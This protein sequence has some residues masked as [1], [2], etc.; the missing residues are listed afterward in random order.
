LPAR[1]P[2][3]FYPLPKPPNMRNLR[4]QTAI[5]FL[6]ILIVGAGKAVAA[7]QPPDN[8]E[9]FEQKIRP[10]LAQRCFSCHSAKTKS[11]QGGLLLDSRAGW[12]RGGGSGSAV[13]PGNPDASLLIKAVRYGSALKMPPTGKLPES[14]I[15]LLEDW[16]KRGAPGPKEAGKPIAQKTG[17]KW[18]SFQPLHSAAL[19]AV[20]NMAWLRTPVDSFILAKLEQKGMKPSPPADRRALIRRATFDLTGLPPT[21]SEI[22][23][24]LSD[25]SPSAYEKVIDRLLISPRYGER[26]GRHWLDVVHYGDTHGYDKDKRRDRAWLYR[27]YVIKAFNDDKPYGRFIREQIAGDVLYPNTPEGIIA[28]GFIVAGPW[29]FV[30]EVE[31]REGTVEKEKTRLL[32]RDDMVANTISTFNS[33]TIHCAR[34]HNHKFDPIPQR[35]YYRLQ[36]VFAGVERGD[37]PFGDRQLIAQRSLL[38]KQQAD[39]GKTQA[40]L[41]KEKNALTSAELTRLDSELDVLKKALAD[42]HLP[43]LDSPSNGY[44]SAISDTA[45]VEKWVQVDLGR[46]IPIDEIRLIPARPTDFPD[47]PGFGFPVRFRVSVSDDPG[48]AASRVIEDLSGSDYPN[49]GDTPFII[50]A[51]GSSTR[52]IRVTAT[53]LWKRTG[54]YVFALAE[55]QVYSQGRNV[56]RGA[57]VTS[58]DSIEAGRWSAKYL[59]DNFD[60]RAALLDASNPKIAADYL[61]RS[62]LQAG[63]KEKESAR[64][65]LAD[66]LVSP[67]LRT[68]IEQVAEKIAAIEKQI[69]ALPKP[70]TA[71]AALSR[72]PRPIHVLARGE[73]TQPGEEVS[74]GGLTCLATLPSEFKT[75]DPQDE[76]GRRAALAEWLS[77]PKNVLTWRS[78]V[79]RVWHYH[80]GRGLVDTPNDFG[81]NG[82][83]P[84]HPELL[85]W[86]AGQF[87]KDGQSIKKLHRL[88]ML[89]AT[90]RQSSAYNPQYAKSDADNHFLWRMNRTR[91]DAESVRDSVMAV[92]GVLDLKMGGP[93]FE[94][95]R[96]KDD[97]SPIYDHSAVEKINSPAAMRRTVYRFVVRSVPNP[98]LDCLDCADPNIN[99]PVRNTTLT[100]LQAL[101]LMNDPFIIKQSEAFAKRLSG[102]HTD[103]AGQINAVYNLALGRPATKGEIAALSAYAGKHGLA[104]ACRLIFNTNEFVFVD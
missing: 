18:W 48:F 11:P 22:A 26:W 49:P 16:V 79:N 13:V 47:T 66:T 103:I 77:N 98:F 83:L 76:G 53:R 100:A 89:S 74:A 101:A 55:M 46:S 88:I 39:L 6:S 78:I 92:S 36:A 9:F 97:H 37:R 67:N 82:S 25:R 57:A 93:G 94:L 90:Y 61:R 65:A 10:L 35:D 99:T 81:R 43:M 4:L 34:C 5:A 70:D 72:A 28:T 30:G 52:Y 86:L 69:A 56:A 68:A 104:N 27:D 41:L 29:D 95:F 1:M 91:L 96:F 20:K 38:E 31:L 19:P 42:M 63:I 58:L 87:L 62:E 50:K 102:L 84:T 60:S 51:K 14:E 3:N 21:P 73:V 17:G 59:V 71:Y 75:P 23:A 7:Q 12:L 80:F 32:D 24:F 15:K 8:G 64:Q 40:T 54:D 85:D 44:H 2:L 33:V 45:N